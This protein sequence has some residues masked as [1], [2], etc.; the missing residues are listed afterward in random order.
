MPQ[1]K[2]LTTGILFA[3]VALGLLAEGIYTL[4]AGDPSQVGG[5]LLFACVLA[6][7]AALLLGLWQYRHQRDHRTIRQ[8]AAQWSSS[9]PTPTPQLTQI[10]SSKQR[11]N[12]L[13][14]PPPLH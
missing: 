1:W 4:V 12:G 14:V 5:Y 9:Q 2:A 11:N 7:P 13:F 3:I 10:V 6:L 8:A